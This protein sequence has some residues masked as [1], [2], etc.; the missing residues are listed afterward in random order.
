MA[1][2]IWSYFDLLT[3][4][5]DRLAHGL[6]I[7]HPPGVFAYLLRRQYNIMV[8]HKVQQQRKFTAA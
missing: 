7:F 4:F 5:M 2:S 1:G 6:R 3:E 8:L